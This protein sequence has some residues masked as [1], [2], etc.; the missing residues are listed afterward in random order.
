[1]IRTRSLFLFLLLA[2]SLYMSVGYAQDTASTQRI[3]NLNIPED[4][5]SRIPDD[6]I[7]QFIQCRERTLINHPNK[8]EFDDIYQETGISKKTLSRI[9]DDQIFPF[10][11]DR[12]Y[13]ELEVS[14]HI[15]FDSSQNEDNFNNGPPSPE[16]VITILYLFIG[17]AAFIIILSIILNHL[18]KRGDQE[19]VI[20]ALQQGVEIPY[21]I[22]QGSRQK[23]SIRNAII[24]IT[25]AG[26][27]FVAGAFGVLPSALGIIPLCIGVGVIIALLII[28]D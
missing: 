20:N 21:D 23:S 5:L 17:I 1:M 8:K 2:S 10:L 18:R 24:M 25:M 13:V 27:I 14:E 16:K 26:G 11:R 19:I 12:G 4:L 3:I 22:I 6:Q 7:A 9:P 28:R 15:S